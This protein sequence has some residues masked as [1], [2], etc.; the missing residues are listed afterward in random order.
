MRGRNKKVCLFSGDAVSKISPSNFFPS[1]FPSGGQ[2]TTLVRLLLPLQ[3]KEAKIKG[4]LPVQ[5]QKDAG[6]A[7]DEENPVRPASHSFLKQ[8]RMLCFFHVATFWGNSSGVHEKARF[9]RVF[10][11]KHSFLNKKPSTFLSDS[12]NFCLGIKAPNFHLFLR[13]LLFHH[14]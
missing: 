8:R 12:V 1:P 5:T 2:K 7:F 14:S 13:L 3:E 11:C 9:S 10:L 6:L 4:L